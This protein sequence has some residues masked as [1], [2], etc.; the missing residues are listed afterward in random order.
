MVFVLGHANYYPRFGFEPARPHGLFY[1]SEQFDAS[2][3]VASLAP[4]ALEGFEGEVRYRPEFDA[5]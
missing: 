2:F 3:F 1:K 4:H 5:T